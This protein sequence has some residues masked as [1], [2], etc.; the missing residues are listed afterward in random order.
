MADYGSPAWVNNDSNNSAPTA[1]SE[2][3]VAP[4]VAVVATGG[5]NG[6]GSTSGKGGC[7]L[8]MLSLHNMGLAFMM[9]VLGVLTILSWG[10]TNKSSNTNASMDDDAAGS[11]GSSGSSSSGGF[12]KMS[13]GEPFLAFYMILFAVLLFLYELM[14]WSPMTNLNDNM[15]KNFGFMYGLRGKGLYLIFVAFLCFGLGKDASVKILNYFTG[16]S[17]LAAGILHIFVI[18]Y[19]P[20]TAKE[21]QPPRSSAAVHGDS[22]VD[23][24]V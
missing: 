17:F 15:R 24:V 23:N 12:F 14:W 22:A 19:R 7:L 10:S 11:S 18:C 16:V 4:G 9:A 1:V 5:K 3:N 2:A 20:E 13:L 6:Q 8:T 21:Y